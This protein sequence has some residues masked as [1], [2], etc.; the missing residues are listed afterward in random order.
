MSVCS[1][2]LVASV[3]ASGKAVVIS[4]FVAI[5]GVASLLVG[6]GSGGKLTFNFE[7]NR[8]HLLT[9]VADHRSGKHTVQ[10]VVRN[11]RGKGVGEFANFNSGGGGHSGS[12]NLPLPA[13]TYHYT[14]YDA[15]GVHYSL[16]WGQQKG[17]I[18]IDS[19][20]VKVP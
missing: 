15:A 8:G 1:G 3:R 17:K 12:Y 4:R 6:C 11:T 13:G 18:R 7:V 19:G 5:L 20:S 2:E 10:L 14:V 16:T 9:T